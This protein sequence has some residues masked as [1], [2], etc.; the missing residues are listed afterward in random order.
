MFTTTRGQA[1]NNR[2]LSL[3]VVTLSLILW[4]YTTC[5]TTVKRWPISRPTSHT[6]TSWYICISN[7]Q[8]NSPSFMH[9]KHPVTAVVF[10]L[11]YPRL[12]LF[13]STPPKRLRRLDILD[14][15]VITRFTEFLK[16]IVS[17][18]GLLRLSM[19]LW[20]SIMQPFLDDWYSRFLEIPYL[21]HNPRDVHRSRSFYTGMTSSIPNLTTFG[22]A[23]S[24]LPDRLTQAPKTS[25][26]AMQKPPPDVVTDLC[27]LGGQLQRTHL[28][29]TCITFKED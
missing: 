16:P 21:S 15:P 27:L 9:M 28:L 24:V 12:S 22:F 10:K 6:Y 1:F 11:L 26:F 5:A 20:G 19:R 3:L 8:T 18:S 7:S 4:L 13:F 17:R 25:L 23:A 2:N 29:T 14:Y